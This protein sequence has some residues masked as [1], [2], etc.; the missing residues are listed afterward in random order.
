MKNKYYSLLTCCRPKKNPFIWSQTNMAEFGLDEED[1]LSGKDF[2]DFDKRIR[3]EIGKYGSYGDPDDGLQGT[4]ISLPVVSSQVKEKII[5]RGIADLQFIPADVITE[6]ETAEYWIINC[7]Q[8]IKAFDYDNSQYHAK[9][10]FTGDPADDRIIRY[11]KKFALHEELI[12]GHD[13][14]VLDYPPYKRII[15]SGKIKN[16]FLK[17]RFS[18]WSFNPVMLT[19]NGSIIE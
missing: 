12:A 19:R 11:V 16:L 15:V 5:C 7:M 14:F 18:G 13:M 6:N 3:F 17:N 4:M 9:S 2:S 1:F 10:F 8:C